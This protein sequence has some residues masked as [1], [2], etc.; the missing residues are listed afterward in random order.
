MMSQANAEDRVS[1]VTGH[2]QGKVS[3]QFEGLQSVTT[4]GPW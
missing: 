4:E 3:A 2:S 1:E